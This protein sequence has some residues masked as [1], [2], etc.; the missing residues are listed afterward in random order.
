MRVGKVLSRLRLSLAAV[1]VLAFA[2]VLVAGAGAQTPGG[3]LPAGA[4]SGPYDIGYK[5]FDPTETNVPYLAWRGEEVRLVKC[6][7]LIPAP[8]SVLPNQTL[9]GFLYGNRA[10]IFIEDWSGTQVNN[11]FEGPKPVPDTFVIFHNNDDS[12]P[13]YG[14]NCLRADFISNKPGMAIIKMSASDASGT[15]WVV[16][17]FLVGWMSVN[18]ANITNP[19]PVTEDAGF[20]PG[21]SANVQVTGAIPLN[22]EFQDDWGLDS[23]LV[24]PRDWAPWAEAMATTDQN[25]SY[26]GND[27]SQYWDIHDSSGPGG[28]GGNPDVH[29]AGYC[30]PNLHPS[31]TIDQVDNC[32]AGDRGGRPFSRVFGDNGTGHGPFDQLYPVTLLSDGNLNSFDAPLPPLKIVFNSSGGMGGFDNFTPLSD[33]TC[34][35]NR[36]PDPCNGG[37]GFVQGVD[38]AAH[39]LYAPYYDQYIP[40]TSR[41]PYGTAS[42]TDG[43]VDTNYPS[44]IQTGQPNNFAGYGWYG[45]YHNWQIARTLVQND[46]VDTPCRLRDTR[47]GESIVGSTDFRQTNGLPTSIIEFTDE[48]GEARAQWQP[49]V[50]SDLF[51]TDVGFVDMNGGCD[52]ENVP[53]PSQTITAA[54]RYPFQTVSQDIQVAGSI[55]KNINNLFHKT[56]S[57]I[58][59][60]NVSSA[61]AYI[62]T[63]TA[64]DI[65]GRGDTFNGEKVCFSREPANVW[66]SVGGSYPHDNGY[67]VYLHDGTATAPATASAETDATRIGE[68]I[69][70]V[71]RFTDE[72]LIRDACITV[73]DPASVDGPCSGVGGVSTTTTTTTTT[74]GTGTTGTATTGTGTAGTTGTGSNTTIPNVKSPS[75]PTVKKAPA[76]ASVVSVQLVMKAKGNRVL[77]VKIHSASKTARIQ[78][79]LVNAKGR[80][81]TTV[82]RTVKTNVRVAVSNLR[83]SPS[84]K[85]VRV[86]VLS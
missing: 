63:V 28:D 65:D 39:K 84:V 4:A 67:C 83:I 27:P 80:V 58:R 12:S 60:D 41:D 54:A 40:A 71:A 59:K 18:S 43:P 30:N 24:L 74:T 37:L 70:V 57:C 38:N 11:S 20:L 45:L 1:V 31:T 10:S 14:Q 19:G 56:L 64:Q 26:S 48:H 62:C 61:I 42:G 5:A 81:I 47:N 52:L 13:H 75:A 86:K 69:D 15:Q 34:V 29:V 73:G 46:S 68:N 76:R 16:H 72:H 22:Q 79:R 2:G 50:N 35:Y 32:N 82:V 23:Q 55:T 21:N 49:G 44:Y 33:K 53:L 9:A 78:I 17:S 85:S 8:S 51:G 7:N 66:Y 6:S 3:G 25:L 77:M 36:G